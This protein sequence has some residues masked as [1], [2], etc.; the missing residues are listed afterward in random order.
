MQ[1]LLKKKLNFN[2]PNSDDLKHL[3]GRKMQNL[4][5]FFP[6]L[7]ASV[8][9]CSH[10]LDD[11]RLAVSVSHSQTFI[12]F[13]CIFFYSS[14]LFWRWKFLHKRKPLDSVAE[15]NV[16]ALKAFKAGFAKVYFQEQVSQRSILCEVD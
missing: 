7:Y 12:F 14:I 5:P 1:S 3:S 2:L 6:A 13:P 9:Q 11:A 10:M 4:K 8:S 15:V 16:D